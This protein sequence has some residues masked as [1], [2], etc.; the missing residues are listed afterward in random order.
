MAVNDAAQKPVV[1]ANNPI[2]P[3]KAG[4]QATAG[5]AG[6]QAP[7]ANAGNPLFPGLTG[8]FQA[9]DQ[10]LFG[11]A[12]AFNNLITQMVASNQRKVNNARL[13]QQTILAQKDKSIALAVE[14]S[15][16][17]YGT[18]GRNPQ[19]PEVSTVSDNLEKPELTAPKP[20][21]DKG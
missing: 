6:N 5:P 4:G 12:T 20:A 21:E 2:Q 16:A 8:N 10:S 19:I 13:A 17:R 7:L 11:N 1:I 15:D 3:V 14:A 18:D 9:D